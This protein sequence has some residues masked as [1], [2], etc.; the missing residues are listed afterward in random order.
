MVE[1]RF[2]VISLPYMSRGLDMAAAFARDFADFQT[3]GLNVQFD[4]GGGSNIVFDPTK[5]GLTLI[6]DHADLNEAT[7]LAARCLKEW[8]THVRSELVFSRVGVR[9]Q[10]VQSSDMTRQELTEVCSAFIFSDRFR[11]TI[12][13]DPDF[14]VTIENLDGADGIRIVLGVMSFDE[15]LKK[16]Q[17]PDNTV[18][19]AGSFLTIDTDLGASEVRPQDVEQFIRRSWATI[20]ERTA[21]LVGQ[22][23]IK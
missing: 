2:A 16:W 17:L 3:N 13:K 5:I 22:I 18:D 4:I 15:L 10:S 9:A 11:S 1:L 21:T 6:A 12:P 23:G 20:S 8:A 14:A 19:D 7:K